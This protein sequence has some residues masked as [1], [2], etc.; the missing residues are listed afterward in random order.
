LK[1]EDPDK[2]KLV[3]LRFFAGLSVEEA[4]AIL[5]I[6]RATADRWWTY[7]RAFLFSQMQQ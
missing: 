7:A 2:A 5:K 1:R 3:S 4:S 6:S